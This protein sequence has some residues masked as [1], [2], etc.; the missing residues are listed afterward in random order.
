VYAA[1]QQQV[2]QVWVRGQQLI[3]DGVP[4]RLDAA[5]ILASAQI[6][7]ERLAR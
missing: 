5:R 6:W 7:G 4:T 1:S 2:R 3:R